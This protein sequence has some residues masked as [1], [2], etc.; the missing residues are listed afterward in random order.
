ARPDELRA[1]AA[2]DPQGSRRRSI[3]RLAFVAGPR[4]FDDRRPASPRLEV[5]AVYIR[6]QHFARLP[7]LGVIERVV[8]AAVNAAHAGFLGGGPETIKGALG[9]QQSVRRRREAHLVGPEEVRENRSAGGAERAMAR[10]VRGKR[11]RFQQRFPGRIGLRV[12][13]FIIGGAV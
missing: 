7:S 4:F 12:P 8:D 1:A 9:A 5:I 10:R 2:G 6:A 13:I 11:W 3:R